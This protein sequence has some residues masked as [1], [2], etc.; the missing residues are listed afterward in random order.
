MLCSL[1]KRCFLIQEQLSA[2]LTSDN[3][4]G[5]QLYMTNVRTADRTSERP[6]VYASLQVTGADSGAAVAS[7]DT[8]A[9]RNRNAGTCDTPAYLTLLGNSPNVD[10]GN[11]DDA[12]YEVVDDY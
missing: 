10:G 1:H 3:Y 2:N 11:K 5:L 8:T 9:D 6:N 7:D 12:D 4:D